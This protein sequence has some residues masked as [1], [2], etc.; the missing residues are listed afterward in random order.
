MNTAQQINTIASNTASAPVA[1]EA[2]NPEVV[3]MYDHLRRFQ[4]LGKRI[5]VKQP[6]IS[7][8]RSP[9]FA[10]KVTPFIPH[11][12]SRAFI[13]EDPVY[14]LPDTSSGIISDPAGVAVKCVTYDVPPPLGIDALMYRYWT[15][16]LI[17]SFRVISSA[18]SQGYLV[19][20]VS[21]NKSVAEIL[22][23]D[24]NGYSKQN[25]WR[26]IEGIGSTFQ[27]FMLESYQQS[28][29]SLS[30]HV[31]VEVPYNRR[32][33]VTDTYEDFRTYGQS[34]VSDSPPVTTQQ[35]HDFVV[36]GIRGATF[37]GSSIDELVI[38]LEISAGPDF[39]FFRELNFNFEAVNQPLDEAIVFPDT[40]TLNPPLA[41]LP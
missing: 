33:P 25:L 27:S 22:V 39:R 16:T 30:R 34:L 11:P 23:G 28:D 8:E 13:T 36:V 18:L 3:T 19:T 12:A 5:T 40:P 20:G 14:I 2:I 32:L 17:Y 6:F 41:L 37:V 7:N 1:T 35:S 26:E 15:G 10:I 24:N 38:E 4:P 9:I 31:K 29:L 21:R